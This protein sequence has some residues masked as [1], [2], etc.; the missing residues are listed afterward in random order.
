MFNS[1]VSKD[2][3]QYGYLCRERSYIQRTYGLSK[4]YITRHAKDW[5][6]CNEMLKIECP[7]Y[8]IK[9]VDTS[10]DRKKVLNKILEEITKNEGALKR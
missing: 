1:L 7:K 8:G 4:E 5:Y 2:K 9:Y 6:E 10:K 3:K